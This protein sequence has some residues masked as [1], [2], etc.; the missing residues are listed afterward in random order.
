MGVEYIKQY[1]INGR[2]LVDAFVPLH[3]LVIEFD[4]DYW[5]GNT[6]IFA[7]LNAMQQRHVS[8][9]NKQTAYL[10]QHGFRVLRVWEHV[11]HKTPEIF[12]QQLTALL[13]DKG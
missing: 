9:D 2:S 12:I 7:T 10:L 1:P 8:H 6:E 5:H 4:G 3:N 13:N 11:I